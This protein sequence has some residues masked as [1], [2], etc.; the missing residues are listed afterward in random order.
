MDN[1][2]TRKSFLKKASVLTLGFT[3]LGNYLLANS[4]NTLSDLSYS[5][6]KDPKG[7]L[8]LPPGFKYKI[9]SQFKDI[10]NDGLQVP[11]HADGMGCF[12]ID[13]ERVALIRNHELGRFEEF[14]FK[15]DY[16]KSAFAKINDIPDW[17]PLESMYDQCKDGNPCYG[18]T[19]TTIYNTKNFNVENEYLS[20]AGT[21]VNCSGGI[22]PWGTWIT[23]EETVATKNSFLLKNHGY[24][25]EVIPSIKR[26]LANP[27]PIKSM[28]RF[29]HEAVAF[30]N[31]ETGSV[32]QTE[33]RKNG[34]IYR[35]LPNNK[36]KL[37]NGGRLQALA[38]IDELSLDTRNW[39]KQKIKQ[40][41]SFNVKWFDLENVESPNDD[42]REQGFEKGCAKFARPEG[43]WEHHGKIYFT[44]TSGGKNELG[45]IWEYTPSLHEGSSK[46]QKY[47]AKLK[48]FFES[49]DA[50]SL[51]MC[52]NITISPFGDIIICEDG[53]GSD[54]LVG[55]KSD[56]KSYKIA[57][58]ILNSS[59][60]AGACFS[61][62]G[63]ILF[64]NIYKPSITLAIT[65]NWANLTAS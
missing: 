10:M 14:N 52:D 64:V 39:K 57:K 49:D 55:I 42:L 27:Q 19:T 54:Y 24:N 1:K 35:F 15:T 40:G 18:G 45:Q 58:N 44:C 61:P 4:I 2:I 62:D 13:S 63:K 28:G 43:M 11:N 60:F 46:E 16:S 26:K 41:E 9:V 23:C 53:K 65:G 36:T 31:G 59:E 3:G 12:K 37:L 30:H 51:D 34:L 25:F 22:T 29:R 6:V 7:I 38:F 56:G 33:D 50:K 8:N 20:L 5:L 32:Y 48:L 47:P 21:L 17:Y